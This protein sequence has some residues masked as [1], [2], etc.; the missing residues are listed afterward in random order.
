MEKGL[1]IKNIHISAERKEIIKGISISIKPGEIHALMGP[2]GSGKST[3][4]GALMGNSK[5]KIKKG[6]FSLNGK[7]LLSMAANQRAKEGLFLSFQHP[8]DIP[9]VTV[10]NFLFTISNIGKKEDEKL[11][12]SD[13]HKMVKEKLKIFQIDESFLKRYVNEGFSG[14][15][16]K[17]FEILQMALLEP[18]MAILD[19]T[20]SGTDVDALRILS[21]GINAIIKKNKTGVL[22]I[23]HYTRILQY[24]KPN[25]VHVMVDGKIVKSGD[26]KLANQIEKEGYSKFFD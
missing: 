19:E 12:I 9:G 6:S 2:N 10:A 5:F 7:D 24:I 17:K 15:E 13:F 16:K 20:D 18:K 8:V 11:S 21:N 4:A 1:V 26:N 23:T 14:G 22:L 3:F 25:Y